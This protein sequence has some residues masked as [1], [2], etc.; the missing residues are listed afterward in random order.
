MQASP[1]IYL[2]SCIA[3]IIAADLQLLPLFL[4]LGFTPPYGRASLQAWCDRHSMDPELLLLLL[5]IF[6]DTG[7]P[8]NHSDG[9]K[10]HIDPIARLIIDSDRDY[11]NVMMPNIARHF[12]LLASR[13]PA[14][15]SHLKPLYGFF[16]IISAKIQQKDAEDRKCLLPA[17]KRLFMTDRIA[18]LSPEIRTNYIKSLQHAVSRN[19][20]LEDLFGDM[21]SYFLSYLDGE[22]D[23]N[24]YVAVVSAISACRA[25]LIH[26]GRI[27]AV[28]KDRAN[29]T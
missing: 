27:I 1:E 23:S 29:E 22:F 5:R 2:H 14:S 20:E 21:L 13:D 6:S 19:A 15:Q 17:L 9:L 3:D 24:L 10:K 11:I 16:E 18:P 12:K 26:T 4:R 28:L 25:D 7:L 8:E